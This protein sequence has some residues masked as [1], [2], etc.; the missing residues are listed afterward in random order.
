MLFTARLMRLALAVFP[1]IIVLQFLGASLR[2]VAGAVMVQPLMD[3]PQELIEVVREGGLE[4]LLKPS[5]ATWWG[6]AGYGLILSFMGVLILWGTRLHLF[7]ILLLTTVSAG[8]IYYTT[9]AVTTD[10]QTWYLSELAF[11]VAALAFSGTFSG[12]AF[13]LVLRRTGQGKQTA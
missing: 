5:L 7:V 11:N 8:T 1:G 3:S 4:I 9:I 2:I 12:W 6:M 10:L 13:W